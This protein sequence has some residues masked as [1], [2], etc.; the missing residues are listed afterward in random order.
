M[1]SIQGASLLIPGIQILT[2]M[3]YENQISAGHNE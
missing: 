3:N 1:I 2:Q